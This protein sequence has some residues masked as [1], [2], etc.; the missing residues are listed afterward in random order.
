MRWCFIY[1]QI[2]T[3]YVGIHTNEN[4]PIIDVADYTQLYLKKEIQGEALVRNLPGFARFLPIAALLNGQVLNIS[5]IAR[6]VGVARV[7][8]NG[9][10]D[11]LVDTLLGFRLPA[12]EA[13][14]RVRE[15]RHPK[16]Y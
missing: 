2:S 13:K 3:K 6:D 12:Y 4:S 7:T 14:L 5:N 9:Y 11:I 8:V 16:W 1:I 10:L 15:R